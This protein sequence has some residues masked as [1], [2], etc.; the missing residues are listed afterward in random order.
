MAVRV[1]TVAKYIRL[2][3]EDADTR[4]GMKQESNSIVAQRQLLDGFI[5]MDAGL[6]NAGCWNFVMTGSAGLTSGVRGSRD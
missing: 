4:K 2:S 6:K 3:D 5:G 1:D